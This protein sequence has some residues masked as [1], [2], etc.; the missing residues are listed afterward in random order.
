MA[1]KTIYPSVDTYINYYAADTN[2]DGATTLL[3]Y[4]SWAAFPFMKFT[5]IPNGKII[6]A[7]LKAYYNDGAGTG[8]DVVDIKVI[9]SSWVSTTMTWNTG[10]P[11]IGASYGSI[12]CGSVT[13]AKTSTDLKTLI[14]Y[15]QTNPIYGIKLIGD[16]G[17]DC[18]GTFDSL[19]GT[20]KPYLEITYIPPSGFSGGQPMI[21]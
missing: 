19:E 11:T 17:V 3:M 21:F 6:S 5:G 7:Y 13:G 16:G 4:S 14:E 12:T 9:T 15:W 20:N 8:Q 10:V 1:V 18:T 2:Y